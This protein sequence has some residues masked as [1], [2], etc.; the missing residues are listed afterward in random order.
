MKK[1]L[2]KAADSA[3]QSKKRENRPKKYALDSCLYN[4]GVS[5]DPKDR[6]CEKCGWNPE[7]LAA[8]KAANKY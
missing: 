4:E 7:V 3:G 5:C 6:N 1:L 8:R 2:K